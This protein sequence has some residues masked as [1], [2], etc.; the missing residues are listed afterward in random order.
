MI[1]EITQYVSG[2][3]LVA[4]AAFGLLAS[5]G[6]LRLPDLYSRMHAAS[7]AGIVG[8]GLIFVGIAVVSLDGAVILRSLIGILFLVLTTPVSAHLLARA[9][10][11]VGYQPCDL[12][13]L[14]EMEDNTH[15]QP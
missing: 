5:L 1:V 14:N 6:V 7:K 11:L 9:A 15:T 3:L 4:G 13:V 10:Y 8:A 12:T 2:L